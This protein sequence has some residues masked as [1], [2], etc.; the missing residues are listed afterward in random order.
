MPPA[1]E[2]LKSYPDMTT[3][4]SGDWPGGA[5]LQRKALVDGTPDYL[6]NS[7]AAP[8]IRA[9]VPQAKFVIILRVGPRALAQALHFRSI[10]RACHMSS[11]ANSE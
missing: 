2:F 6:F 10:S 4:N 1:V 7:V 9:V 8:R 5:Y 11:V 3:Q